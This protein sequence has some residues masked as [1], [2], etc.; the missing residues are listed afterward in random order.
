M[1]CYETIMLPIQRQCNE[2]SEECKICQCGSDMI[3]TVA[4]LSSQPVNLLSNLS[5]KKLT[6]TPTSLNMQKR[7]SLCGAVFD[8]KGTKRKM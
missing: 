8:F 7:K 6:S 2:I 4:R 3:H 1:K 5:D